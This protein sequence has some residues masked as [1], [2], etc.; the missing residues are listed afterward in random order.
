MIGDPVRTQD[1]LLLG[2]Y[3]A[4]RIY[5]VTDTAAHPDDVVDLLCDRIQKLKPFA[6][7][8]PST[9]QGREIA[10]RIAARLNLGL[11]GDCVGLRWDAEGRLSN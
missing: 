6:F 1:V 9:P 2:A 4:D 11:T 10:P 7:F 8:L 3:G 5:H